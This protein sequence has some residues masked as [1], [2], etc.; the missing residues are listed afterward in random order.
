[1]KSVRH[2]SPS[3]DELG[4]FSAPAPVKTREKEELVDTA[5]AITVNA[6]PEV[7]YAR[8]RNLES[9]PT[10]MYHLESVTPT[11]GRRS[12][13]VA[14]APTGTV[15]WDADI[16]DDQPGRQIAWRSVEGSTVGNRGEVRF[17]PAPK[18]QGTEIHVKLSY[19]APAGKAGSVVAKLFG[20]EPSQQV[21]DD[22]RRFKQ[23]VET[24]EIARSDGSPR[25]TRTANMAR[26]REAQPLDGGERKAV[27]R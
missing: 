6:S 7:V 3:L 2:P 8:W 10:F 5:S 13:W 16:T 15:E 20:E 27:D 1:V 24:G 19:D 14:K 12:H 21:S 17:V 18:G 23:L 26:R 22:L 25:G 9:L 11:D 4:W